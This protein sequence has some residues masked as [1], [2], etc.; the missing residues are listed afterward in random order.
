VPLRNKTAAPTGEAWR[1]RRGKVTNLPPQATHESIKYF[2]GVVAGFG[3]KFDFDYDL[4]EAHTL[5]K[6]VWATVAARFTLATPV[7]PKVLHSHAAYVILPDGKD[8]K[9]R[10]LMVGVDFSPPAGGPP[11]GG[12]N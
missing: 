9:L 3:P 1:G 5:G 12:S 6:G 7:G 8:W 11:P 4:H 10:L 2:V